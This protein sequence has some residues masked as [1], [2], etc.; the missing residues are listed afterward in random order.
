MERRELLP[1]ILYMTP[2]KPP[3]IQYALTQLQDS[4]LISTKSTLRFARD[5]SD[6]QWWNPIVPTEL[7][8]LHE[9]GYSLAVISNQKG[10]S[11]KKDS[12]TAK[13]DMKSLSNF[14][15]KAA[16]VFAR[17]DLPISIY[18]ATEQDRHRKPRV[19]MWSEMLGDYG[20]LQEDV[21]FE[22]SIFVGDAAG[23]GE[24]KKGGDHS[25]SDRFDFT[26][27]QNWT[28]EWLMDA[29]I[30][31]PMLGFLSKLPKSIS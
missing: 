4:T 29:G 8:R 9:E 19:G 22:G 31:P 6:W 10:I 14:K 26:L 17:L 12:K 11:L 18:A 23:R 7:R 25:C 30:L 3:N 27:E 20:L 24:V 15:N 1:S 21:D 2:F 5:A 13:G 28:L 16:I